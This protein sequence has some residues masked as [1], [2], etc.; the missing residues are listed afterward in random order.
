[1]RTKIWIL[2]AVTAVTAA[3]GAVGCGSSSNTPADGG[4]GAGGRGGQ[5]GQAAAGAGGGKTDGGGAGA[6]TDGGSDRTDAA[7]GFMVFAPCASESDYV[8]ATTEISFGG[9]L[10]FNYSPACLKIPPATTVTFNGDF[11]THPLIPSI[12]RTLPG[13]SPIVATTSTQRAPDVSFTFYAP[14]FYGYF[15]GAHG[16]DEGDAMSGMIWVQ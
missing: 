8:S 13:P 16:D 12:S 15:C 11:Q 1:M 9:T 14:G 2:A 10:G 4:A 3:A 5:G 7:S 6:R